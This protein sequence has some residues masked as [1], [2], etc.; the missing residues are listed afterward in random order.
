MDVAQ[1][2]STLVGDIVYHLKTYSRAAN[3]FNFY[4]FV[5]PTLDTHPMDALDYSHAIS[6]TDTVVVLFYRHEIPFPYGKICNSGVNQI[7]NRPIV[8][9]VIKEPVTRN[10][11]LEKILT[12][13]RVETILPDHTIAAFYIL[14]I[15]KELQH[16]PE[17]AE[18]YVYVNPTVD[19]QP[20]D[21]VHQDLGVRPV[22]SVVVVFYEPPA[23]FPYG[24]D[25]GGGS[26]GSF[27]GI[28]GR[29]RTRTRSRSRM[30]IRSRSKSTSKAPTKRRR[31]PVSR[32]R[33]RR[34]RS[35]R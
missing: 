10:E 29:V 6:A 18:G 16:L 30:R 34:S 21:H 7:E 4:V 24:G 23:T 32:S 22:D 11:W 5:N 17:D 26:G 3:E 1:D 2:G 27:G 28:K 33:S 31:K 25:G 8:I 12:A 9:T 35:R 14:Q 13:P 15:A 20:E 19:T